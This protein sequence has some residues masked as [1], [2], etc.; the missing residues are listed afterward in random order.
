MGSSENKKK[1]CFSKKTRS[2]GKSSIQNK[3]IKILF[4]RQIGFIYTNTL[5]PLTWDNWMCMGVTTYYSFCESAKIGRS[6]Y[7][8]SDE[9]K[10]KFWMSDV[11]SNF[12]DPHFASC[13]ATSKCPVQGLFYC[14]PGAHL[15]SPNRL[16]SVFST[17]N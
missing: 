6:I 5:I 10:W 13:L 8:K 16:L 7:L 2:F 15:C 12:H 17:D 1:R 4:L 3:K 14:A 11:R 9:M